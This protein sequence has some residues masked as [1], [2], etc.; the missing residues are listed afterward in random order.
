MTKTNSPFIQ[1]KREAMLSRILDTA[2]AIMLEEGVAAL[3][4][5][6]LARRMNMRAPSLYNY[7]AS[8][9]EIYD[10]LFQLGYRKFAAQIDGYLKD[11][12]WQSQL[13]NLMKNYM[14]FAL[15]NPE[16]YQLC[17]ER[18][19]PGFVPSEESLQ[20]SFGI[21]E[22]TYAHVK[23]WLP[24]L[25][26]SLD[27]RQLTDLLIAINHGITALHLANQAD[28]PLEES[29]FASLTPSVVTLIAQAW[30]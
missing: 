11:G 3:S 4:M 30:A 20:I 8:K 29:R 24:S 18:P 15:Q 6:E 16:L 26:T 28:V 19:V 17:F 2:R 25:N 9:M 12:G 10:A 1:H 23:T 14:D 7:F 22:R 13:S 5:Q 27:E 21:L